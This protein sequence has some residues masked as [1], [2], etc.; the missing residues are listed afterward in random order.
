VGF[1]LQ[2]LLA[3]LAEPVTI[4]EARKQ[5]HLEDDRDDVL[6]RLLI[7]AARG[8]AERITGKQLVEAK[9]KYTLDGFPASG[10]VIRL[11]RPPLIAVVFPAVQYYA[12][13]GTLTTLA[14]TLYQV[15]AQSE[16]ARIAEAPD[17]TWESTES[18]RLN[19]VSITYLAGSLASF[20]A[21]DTTNEITTNRP[22]SDGG[23]VRLSTS[24][25]G[26]LPGGLATSTDYYVRD[27]NAAGTTFKL[28]ATAGGSA[29][30]L[31]SAGTGTLYLGEV[32]AD[33][34]EAMRLLLAHWYCFREEGVEMVN[35]IINRIPAGA[36]EILRGS[37]HGW[38]Y[39]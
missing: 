3:P 26:A 32:P 6:L 39:F 11:P 18:G 23:T 37:W 31:T 8:L 12:T 28:A 10:S 14:T 36:Q 7:S 16:P 34:K 5:V 29:I 38:K 19:A 9:Y 35:D 1:G 27:A 24:E 25:G 22:H 17:E 2:T 33:I 21:N 30:D 4:T 20:T 13:T 15:D